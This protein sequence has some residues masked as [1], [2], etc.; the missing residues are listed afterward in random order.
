V[1]IVI[2]GYNFLK[3][4]TGTKFINDMV[5]NSWLLRFQE[6]VQVRHNKVVVVFDAGPYFF[7]MQEMVGLVEVWY[8]GQSQSADD[9][10]KNWLQKNKNSD[11]LLVT[12]DRDVRQW[13]ELLN[14][15]SINS[16]DFYKIFTDVMQREQVQNK[17]FHASIFKTKKNDPFDEKLDFLM[18]QG[19][20]NLVQDIIKNGPSNSIRLSNRKKISKLD[21]LIMKKI[22][23]I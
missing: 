6:Y 5:L 3:S 10:L 13:A 7:Q 4:V 21:S 17:A 12:S 11:L 9:L 8:S 2:D 14:I 1:I 23:K 18:D 22:D 20:K 19:S 15:L 16:Q